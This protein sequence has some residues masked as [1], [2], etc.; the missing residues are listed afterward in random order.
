MNR[1]RLGRRRAA[2]EGKQ[3]APRVTGLD[4][5]GVVDSVGADVVN[6]RPGDQVIALVRSAYAEYAVADPVLTYRPP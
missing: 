1:A 6:W 2:A 5:A 3:G 4:V